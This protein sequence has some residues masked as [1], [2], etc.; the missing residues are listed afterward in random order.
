MANVNFENTFIEKYEIADE[1]YIFNQT[2][3]FLNYDLWLNGKT[4][5]LYI[6]GLSGSGKGYYAKKVADSVDDCIIF[7][8]DKFENYMWFLDTTDKEHP[9]VA[10]GDKIIFDYLNTNFDLSNDIFDNNVEKYNSMMKDFYKYLLDIY[11]I[12]SILSTG[13]PDKSSVFSEK[14]SV[15]PE[16]GIRFFGKNLFSVICKRNVCSAVKSQR[17]RAAFHGYKVR[18]LNYFGRGAGGHKIVIGIENMHM[19]ATEKANNTTS[20]TVRLLRFSIL[21]LRS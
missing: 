5:P 4:N 11:Y 9:A 21:R 17:K 12:L 20:T 7:E 3:V 19:T 18:V 16:K 15:F 2:P 14:V 10:R 13:F 1:G 6:T 8:L